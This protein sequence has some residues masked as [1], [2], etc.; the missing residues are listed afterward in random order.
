MGISSETGIEASPIAVIDRFGTSLVTCTDILEILQLA[1][2][3][4][5]ELLPEAMM[6]TTRLSP[7]GSYL[8]GT[9]QS[10]FDRYL[11]PAKQLFGIDPF[12]K[13]FSV[14]G[15]TAEE[16]KLFRNG[17]LY[18]FADKFAEAFYNLGSSDF[19]MGTPHV[20]C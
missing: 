19:C 17:K 10:G 18:H 3:A 15:M 9:W 1:G 4:V 12:E 11:K 14:S 7:D 5:R 16:L 6:Y 13:K 20:L 2:E 8:Q